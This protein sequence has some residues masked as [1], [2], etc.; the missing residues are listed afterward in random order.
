MSKMIQKVKALK[1]KTP[2][3]KH[4]WTLAQK[5]AL[6]GYAFISPFIIGF[7]AFM[8]SP[9]LESLRMAFSDV[10]ISA[11]A[12]GFQMKFIGIDNFKQAFTVDPEYT[13]L[14]T[15]ELTSMLAD[16]PAILVFSFFVALIL[17][18]EFKG[19]GAVRA[20]FFLPVILSSGVLVG[21]E[22]N[23]SLLQGMED[24]IK[25]SGNSSITTVLQEILV[26]DGMGSSLMKTL[27]NIVDHVYDIAISSGIQIVIFLSG[28]QTISK[29]MYEAA[30]IEGCTA[31][32][33][34]WKITFPMVSS[35]ILVN[36]VYTII[37]FFIRTDNQV[38][39]K[40][41]DTMMVKMDYGFSSAMAWVYFGAVMVIIAVFS[42]IV[43]KGVYYYD[44]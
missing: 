28:L 40:I 43:S 33:K 30:D 18:Q 11:G 2:G 37:D 34:F 22:Y 16:V 31:W 9:M 21:L 42:A 4:E 5:R 14:L 17:N 41:S 13:R 25:E 15:E 39:E 12:G 29:S 1:A 36:L 23:N 19:R 32:E 6:L 3:K 27:F 20:I 8:L 24:I 26:T 7:L 35:T 10:I 44:S 38:M